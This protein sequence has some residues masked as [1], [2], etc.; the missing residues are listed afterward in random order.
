MGPW[1]PP[2]SGRR[3]GW[4]AGASGSLVGDTWLKVT[5]GPNVTGEALRLGLSGFVLIKKN[6]QCLKIRCLHQIW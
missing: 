6:C 5:N 4:S 3:G 2:G 1:L